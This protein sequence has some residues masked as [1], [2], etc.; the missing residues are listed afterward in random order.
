MKHAKIVGNQTGEV[1]QKA[2]G[3]HGGGAGLIS[4]G[5]GQGV[6]AIKQ[7]CKGAG[8]GR[9]ASAPANMGAKG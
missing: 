4:K 5:D 2:P 1:T 9:L 8:G 7:W 6:A 3:G